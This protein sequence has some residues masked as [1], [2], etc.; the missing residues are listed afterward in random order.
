MNHGN[1]PETDHLH[2]TPAAVPLDELARQKAA[3][4]GLN[5]PHGT[6]YIQI[7]HDLLDTLKGTHDLLAAPASA[8]AGEGRGPR[9]RRRRRSHREGV[10][11]PGRGPR[12]RPRRGQRPF[13]LRERL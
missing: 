4:L 10:A 3:A 9:G 2:V 7:I 5:F 6:P 12:G 8:S 11:R 13:E 1:P